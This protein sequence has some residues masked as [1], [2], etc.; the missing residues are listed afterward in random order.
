MS[1]ECIECKGYAEFK[2]KGKCYCLDCL[3]REFDVMEFK[4][5]DYYD[6]Y[7][8]FLGSD[9]DIDLNYVAEIL[10]EDVEVIMK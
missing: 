4:R 10:G 2:F 5:I 3:F 1:K 8:E 6:T 7:G 9:D